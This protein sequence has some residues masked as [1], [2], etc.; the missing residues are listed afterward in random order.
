MMTNE[1]IKHDLDDTEW[2]RAHFIKYGMDPDEILPSPAE[3]N[4]QSEEPQASKK[5]R[6]G[7]L[8]A[9]LGISYRP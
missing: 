1:G 6:A 5:K 3:K 4:A 2:W 9:Y 7:G 8:F